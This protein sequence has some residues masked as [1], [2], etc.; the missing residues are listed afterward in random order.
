MCIFFEKIVFRLLDS[1][2]L[3]AQQQGRPAEYLW[4]KRLLSDEE[5]QGVTRGGRGRKL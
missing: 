3:C 1:K 2:H 4:L 5:W